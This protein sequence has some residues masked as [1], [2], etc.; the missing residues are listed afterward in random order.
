MEDKA[1]QFQKFGFCKY[2]ER[3]V[4]KHFSE[5]CENNLECKDK[6]NC[7]K[8][9]PKAC[10][11]NG[12]GV[13]RFEGDC[14]YSH[15]T[16][17]SPDQTR[18]NGRIELLEKVVIELSAKVLSQEIELKEIKANKD[19]IDANKNKEDTEMKEKV[20]LLEAVVQKMFLN[21]I[22]LEAK[23]TDSTTKHKSIVTSEEAADEVNMLDSECK[24]RP[25]INRKEDNTESKESSSNPST[26]LDKKDEG[27]QEEVDLKC[28]M[29]QYTCKKRKM[30]IKHMNTKH[31]DHTCKICY[32]IFPN[33]M[34]ALVHTATDHTKDIMEDISKT[35]VPTVKDM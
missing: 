16:S 7:H 6:I 13:C 29:C 4:K 9:H 35:D 33:S 11:R 24:N 1:C 34:D 2:K 8:R 28:D 23:V 12:S 14:A 22:K 31:K 15:K 25:E 20:K 26:V 5:E 19:N 3:C 18:S 27:K 30:L 10:K 32:K 17:S 21:V